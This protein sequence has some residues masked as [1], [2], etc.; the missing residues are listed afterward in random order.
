MT[1]HKSTQEAKRV[2]LWLAIEDFCGLWEVL[3][4]LNSSL[5]SL[6][7]GVRLALGKSLVI[8][9]LAKGLLDAYEAVEPYEQLTRVPLDQAIAACMDDMQWN[10]PLC[11]SKTLRMGATI[12]GED[13]Y[14]KMTSVV[15][16]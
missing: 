5:P 12:V 14:R 2:I 9:M 16:T 8:D 3:W 6:S 10:E 11:G 7:P 15:S 13:I 1:N 4:Q